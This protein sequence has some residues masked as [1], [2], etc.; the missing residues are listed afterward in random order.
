MPTS[1]E[2]QQ[3]SESPPR[4]SYFLSTEWIKLYCSKLEEVT[5]ELTH[6]REAMRTQSQS[7]AP[8]SHLNSDN[9]SRQQSQS[10]ASPG[11]Y[12]GSEGSYSDSGRSLSWGN[13]RTTFY[14]TEN[15]DSAAFSIGQQHIGDV[16]F[17]G[18]LIVELFKQYKSSSSE[19]R[20]LCS[21]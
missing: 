7:V 3:G 11:G 18:L 13:L 14:Q 17:D 5:S 19:S 16:H 21:C 4:R 6:L 1:K 9:R 12:G 2:Y 10:S 8:P 15:S 20:P